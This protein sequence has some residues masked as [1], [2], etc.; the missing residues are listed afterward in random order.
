MRNRARARVGVRVRVRDR[1]R[2]RVRVRDRGRVRVRDRVRGRCAATLGSQ[3]YPY[4]YRS[5]VNLNPNPNPTL[6]SQPV[7]G[8]ALV[9]LCGAAYRCSNRSLGLS[10]LESM[11]ATAGHQVAA[12]GVHLSLGLMPQSMAPA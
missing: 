3:P 10:V 9:Y 7:F 8:S 1:Y 5:N 12:L 4:P 11:L 6:G 2:V